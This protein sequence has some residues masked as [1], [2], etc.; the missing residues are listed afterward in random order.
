MV[1][2][3][4]MASAQLRYAWG[5]GSGN[6]ISSATINGVGGSIT[7]QVYVQDTA[8][9]AP[10]FNSH[11]GLASAAARIT[12]SAGNIAVIS[13]ALD[14]GAGR[15]ET[16]NINSNPPTNIDLSP[17]NLNAGY[18]PDAAGRVLLG[19]VTLRGDAVGS[20]DVVMAD[21]NPAIGGDVTLFDNG[22]VLDPPGVPLI[23]ATLSVT[24]APVPEPAG[25][26]VVTA[27]ALA[28]IRGRR[29]GGRAAARAALTAAA[30][31]ARRR[32]VAG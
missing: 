3:P 19:T 12:G 27:A 25:V 32:S 21:P 30:G 8:S 26:L 4:A 11:G 15:W 16:G 13:G 18:L 5:D 1:A 24:V 20:F 31:P 17:F 6:L 29:A 2:C 10:T 22:Q 7:L 14:L 9:G 23:Q 28:I